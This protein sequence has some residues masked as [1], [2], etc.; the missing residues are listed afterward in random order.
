MLDDDPIRS[1]PPLRAV[2][3]RY[4]LRPQ[5]RLGQNFLLDL[6][7][8]EKI[9]RHAG[10]L[11][12]AVVIEIGP[13]PG[14]LT[15]ALLVYGAQSVIAIEKDHRCIVALQDIV[16]LSQG[17]LRVIEGDAQ[18]I[19]LVALDSSP[20]KIVANLPYNIGTVLLVKWLRLLPAIQ[21]LTLM[22]QKEVA[23]RI[24][25]K[26]A[27][28]HYG[29]L[30]VL[31]NWLCHTSLCFTLP[32]MVFYPPPK[33]ESAVVNLIARQD[34][35]EPTVIEDMQLVTAAAFGQR[36]K[37]LRQ[38]LRS[39]DVDTEKLLH[40]ADLDGTHRAETLGIESF[41]KLAKIYGAMKAK[42]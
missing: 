8:T 39:L 28:P 22:M 35:P 9:A 32:P 13:G 2:I 21:S 30:S 25:A 14:G 18:Q 6:N 40:F 24:I 23:Y 16:D 41:L 17:R 7:I 31:C 33:V 38:S 37:M 5:K 15:R 36:R 19:D 4:G 12:Q 11:D 1:L 29:R 10:K 34:L 20:K 27:T 42:K 26:P 3:N